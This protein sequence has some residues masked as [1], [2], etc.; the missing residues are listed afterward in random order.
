MTNSS[1]SRIPLAVPNISGREWEYVKQALDTGWVSSAGP[2]VSAFETEF[3]AATRAL[4][5]VAVASGT[6]ALHLSLLAQRIR[7]GDEVLLP[8]LTFVAPANAIRYVGAFP[9]FIDVDRRH[10]QL[11]PQAV[12]SFLQDDC[13]PGDRGPVNRHTGRTVSGVVPVD[14]LGHPSD[15][16]ALSAI[17]AEFGL[18]IVEDATESLGASYRSRLLGGISS[19]T[20]FSFNGNKLLTTGGG[21]MVTTND[22]EQAERIRYLSTQAKDDELRY[23]HNEI[24]FNYR[25]TN[26]QAAI[27]RAQLERL[28]EFVANK[29]EI[30]RRY[31][32]AFAPYDMI[33]PQEEARWARSACW[34]STVLLDDRITSGDPALVSVGLDGFGIQTRPLWEPLHRSEAHSASYH[35]PCPVSD[36]IQRSAL[37]LPSSTALTSED[38]SRVIEA[39]VRIATTS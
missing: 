35:G 25:L 34:L 33:E 20:C 19:P 28:G 22:P 16:D 17:A 18:A 37:S 2:H 14:I 23:R 39:I 13:S 11:S 36:Q 38:Q 32:E 26:V 27:G 21:G 10:W 9:T 1:G 12:R 4:H 8:S 29:R 7:P 15:L 30:S 3:A 6:A 24:G 5:A 31:V